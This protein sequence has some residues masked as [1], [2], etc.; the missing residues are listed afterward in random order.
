MSVIVQRALPDVRDGLK[1]VHR[2]IIYAM[3]QM[4]LSPGGRNTKSAKV[5]GEVLGKYHPH[6]DMSVYMALVR[7]A[8]EFSLR[9]P[10]VKGQGNFGSIDGDP[11]AAM[12]YTEVKMDKITQEMITDIN[13]ETV[14]MMD[15]F[16]ATI[17]EPVVLP[18][19]IPNLLLNGADGIAVGMATRIPPHNLKELC[20]AIDFILENSRLEKLEEE[21]ELKPFVAKTQTTQDIVLKPVYELER[22]K[23]NFETTASV[24]E[25]SKFVQGPDFPTS[26]EIYGRTGI[27][28]MYNTGRGKFAVRGK[29]AI[30]ETKSGKIR[31]IITELPYQVNKSEFVKKIA[32]L[33]RDKKIIGISDLRDESDRHGIRVVVEIKKN[34]K[35]KSILNKLYKYTALQSSYSANILALVNGVPQ[36][37]NLRQMLL[38]FL[39]HREVIVRRRTVFDL[40][41]AMMRAHI[42]E[43]L[44]IA[45]D[46]IDEIIKTIRA[47]KN[48]EEARENLMSKFKFTDLQANA[49]LEM[50]LR[51]LAALERQKIEDEYNEIKKT[52]DG[53]TSII[54]KT[55][56]MTTVLKTEN[57]EIMEKYGDIRRTKI[58]VRGLEELSEEDLTPNEAV[59]VTITKTG[60]VKRVPKETY[61]SQKRGG[62][63]VVGMTTKMEDEI[64]NMMS[65]N[66]H[67]D[68]LFFT[69]KGRVF[70]TKVW[71]LP[72]SNRQSKGQA[73]VNL[74]NII[75]GEIVQTVLPFSKDSEA[76]FILLATKNG[77]V[78]K[79]SIE[80]FKNIRQSGLAAIKLDADDQLI[81]ARATTGKNQIF[82][83]THNG[84]C[85][86]FD[87]NDIRPMGR[88]TRGVRGI[89]LKENDYVVSLDVV[90]ANIEEVK[91]KKDKKDAKETFR[92]LFVVTENGVGKRTNVYLYPAQKRG[93]IGIKVANLTSKTGKI[94]A[95]QVVSE[96][97]DQVILVSKKAITINMPL[98]N[99]P[100]LNRNTK[101]VILMRFKTTEDKVNAVTILEKRTEGEE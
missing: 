69:N 23:Y 55:E 17:K 47:S 73:I 54:T 75:Q 94:A 66:T 64:E 31:I 48:T 12:R 30:E 88:H 58:F 83:V 89:F 29:A 5:V 50:Q 72:E 25:I 10:L 87:E 68:L 99:V 81:W 26:G 16:D 70:K 77:T 21:L 22:Q 96:I 57:K 56:V 24:E 6:G 95:A 37:L 51:R 61:H 71:D 19:K 59:L 100:T 34:G 32:D 15:N 46:V 2:R 40:K 4:G 18:A 82:M 76:K 90:P 79:T 60:Y 86:R 44:K 92:H 11:P 65:V 1:P 28:E 35:P 93:G 9:Y 74:I 97:H 91:S 3:E 84:K 7:M 62:I 42:L 27:L 33:V 39:R 43:G 67:D 13:K 53:L 41:S 49:I 38:L 101:G 8:Q 98:K 80:R 52:I 78:K 14:D 45:L 85:I 36:T 63:G 20:T